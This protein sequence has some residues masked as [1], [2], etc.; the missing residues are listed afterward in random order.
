[1]PERACGAGAV[2]PGMLP[3]AFGYLEEGKPRGSS[4]VGQLA[5]K[6][7]AKPSEH[8]RC[9]ALARPIQTSSSLT[10]QQEGAPSDDRALPDIDRC[11][12]CS[13]AS[14]AVLFSSHDRL[15]RQPGTF[16]ALECSAC[17]LVRIRPAPPQNPA[18]LNLERVRDDDPSSIVR[19]L[20]NSG[21]RL[22]ARRMATVI[23]CRAHGGAVLDLG[24]GSPLGSALHRHGLAVVSATPT[25][26]PV[27]SRFSSAG[28]SLVQDW[29]PDGYFNRGAYDVIVGKHVLEH[30]HDPRAVVRAMLEMLAPDGWLVIQVPNANSWQA[31][32][33]AGAW[34]GFDVPRHPV[35]FDDA[36][37][38][39]LLDSCG[40]VVD[41][42]RTGSII[43]AALCLATSLC[44]WLDPDLRQVRGVQENRIV[45]GLKD[46]SYCL[47][48]IAVFPLVL[49]E[50]ASDSGPAVLVEAR[51]RI[52]DVPETDRQGSDDG[53]T[54]PA[55]KTAAPPEERDP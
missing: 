6:S 1:M 22:A 25:S 33:L 27:S 37:L 55:A 39:R 38:E 3:G 41:S 10:V 49:L 46:L 52:D 8:L 35:C 2:T 34:E 45:E 29:M 18:T 14:G 30:E 16:E 11:P 36:S 47:V 9:T 43:E 54:N 50:L 32:L 20:I 44:P 17:R 23:R 24:G 42:R 26:R 15:R 7:A 48:V 40:L 28:D 13:S 19:R 53:A 5:M 31:L 21:R 4:Q 12:C 51:R